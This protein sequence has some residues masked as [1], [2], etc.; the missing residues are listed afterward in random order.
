MKAEQEF[1]QSR[2]GGKGDGR[3]EGGG[4]VQGIETVWSWDTL[5]AQGGGE[6]RD[7][8]GGGGEVGER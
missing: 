4:N 2:Q 1:R 6:G 7:R 8:G 5:A 3:R